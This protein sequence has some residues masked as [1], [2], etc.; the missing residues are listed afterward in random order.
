MDAHVTGV[1][2]RAWGNYRSA[3]RSNSSRV[4]MGLAVVSQHTAGWPADG[5]HGL[6][7]WRPLNLSADGTATRLVGDQHSRRRPQPQRL[8]RWKKRKKARLQG[9][10]EAVQNCEGGLKKK[11]MRSSPQGFHC[12]CTTLKIE[13]HRR[14]LQPAWEVQTNDKRVAEKSVAKCTDTSL[15]AQPGSV[16]TH[17]ASQVQ[18][19][20]PGG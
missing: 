3:A 10:C 9:A 1:F 20:Q 6:A 16:T 18:L 5:Q 14:S 17:P 12:K 7:V 8:C 2:E 19:F 13:R 4:H 11:K 15:I